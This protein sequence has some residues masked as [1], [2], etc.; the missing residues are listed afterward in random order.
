MQ[1]S[2]CSSLLLPCRLARPPCR[3]V[4]NSVNTTPTRCGRPTA[5]AGCRDV[6]QLLQDMRF[7]SDAEVPGEWQLRT[8][9]AMREFPHIRFLHVPNRYDWY[10]YSC[11]RGTAAGE[12]RKQG[13]VRS[14]LRDALKSRAPAAAVRTLAEFGGFLETGLL[15]AL[16]CRASED[17]LL[18]LFL[19]PAQL[20]AAEAEAA[21]TKGRSPL[22][23]AIANALWKVA[24]RILEMDPP[25][26]GRPSPR[27][28]ELPFHTAL[29]GT[30]GFPA[31]LAPVL[32]AALPG[33][34]ALALALDSERWKEGYDDR[35]QSVVTALAST[36]AVR[37][38]AAATGGRSPLVRA[39]LKGL[40][41]A[42]EAVLAADPAAAGAR[43]EVE[44]GRFPLHVALLR[45]PADT[46]YRAPPPSLIVALIKA[47]PEA[48]AATD[49]DG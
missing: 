36:E 13:P 20:A 16:E 5:A 26:A 19:S 27:T 49:A 10:D 11:W 18:E 15:F 8:E 39:L 22:E 40:W 17:V 24:G 48:A 1:T 25:A 29:S 45:D 41:A 7:L 28:G 44:A 31:S 2:D 3:F 34:E 30:W 33:G 46:C 6:Y 38:P 43:C 35:R 42:A 37:A 9:R 21:A 47:C 14:A 12:P 23:A 4:G 32:A